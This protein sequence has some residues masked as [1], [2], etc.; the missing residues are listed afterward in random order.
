M[1]SVL[2]FPV[3]IA[4]CGAGRGQSFSY[5]SACDS[6]FTNCNFPRYVLLEMVYTTL[7]II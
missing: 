2:E 1:H 3:P 4:V 6:N 7:Q 5:W